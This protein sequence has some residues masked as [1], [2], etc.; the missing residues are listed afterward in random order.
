MATSVGDGQ[1]AEPTPAPRVRAMRGK[2]RRRQQIPEDIL[3][4]PALAEAAGA[5]P[6]NYNFEVFRAIFCSQCSVG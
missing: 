2:G 6:A 3:N 4:D 5:L 1:L